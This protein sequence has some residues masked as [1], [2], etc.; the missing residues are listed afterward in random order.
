[1]IK[2]SGTADEKRL[3]AK[4]EPFLENP[5]HLLVSLLLVNTA[6]YETLPLILDRIINPLAAVLI[7]VTAVLFFG[8]IL[9][10]AVCKRYGMQVGAF[11]APLVR[12]TMYLTYPVSKPVGKLLD[13]LLGQ[14]TA[15]FRRSE[16]RALVE[17]HGDT[18]AGEPRL[19]NYEVQVRL[20]ILSLSLYFN[21]YGGE[22]GDDSVLCP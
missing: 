16:L 6:A 12:L 15:L 8:E 17:L 2:R 4:V 14:E 3:A 7:S 9:P 11:F 18:H 10:Q 19:S 20:K 21:V 5:H 22:G 1:M 13:Y